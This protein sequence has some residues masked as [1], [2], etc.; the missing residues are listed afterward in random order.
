ME[1]ARK[2]RLFQVRRDMLVW[3]LLHPRL[4]EISFL[5]A[6]TVSLDSFL[7]SNLRLAKVRYCAPHPRSMLA[8]PQS[9]PSS[10][11]S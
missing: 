8:R 3:H 2:F 7:S 6:V 4:E 10:Y 9:K 5:R 1:A 11:S